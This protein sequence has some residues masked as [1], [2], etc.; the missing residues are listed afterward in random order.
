L[1]L[2]KALQEN[3]GIKSSFLALHQ[4]EKLTGT[5]DGFDV[6]SLSEHDE[7]SLL[8]SIPED[9]NCIFLHYC[10]FPYFQGKLKAPFWFPKALKV[11]VSRRKLKLIVMF[12]EL[13]FLKWKKIQFINPVHFLV[14]HAVSTIAV[15]QVTNNSKFLTVFRNS[16]FRKVECVLNFSGIGELDFPDALAKRKKIIVVFGSTDRDRVYKNSLPRILDIYHKYNIEALYDIG[17][18]LNLCD[19]YD[20]GSV[21]LIEMGFQPSHVVS[22]ILS[23][24]LFCCLDYTRF[25]GSLGKSSVFAAAC[26][27]GTV[28]LCTEDNFS[29]RDGL[30]AGGN[31]LVINDSCADWS[32]VGL[33]EV[34]GCAHRWYQSHTLKRGAERFAALMLGGESR[35]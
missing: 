13:P 1:S 4:N 20:F 2:A 30:V 31:Y 32:D 35:H 23:E 6:S 29:D 16:G 14:F 21:N 8:A 26:S 25:P 7:K 17:Q 5:V 9:V 22:D 15:N 24:A 11:A 34:A 19:R 3:H 10:N 28:P 12:H 33:Q 18:P 27:H